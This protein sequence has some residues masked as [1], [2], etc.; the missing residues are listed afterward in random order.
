MALNWSLF[1]RL[2]VVGEAGTGVV[3]G[4]DKGER[5]GAGDAAREDVLAELL[6]VAGVLGGA[7]RSLDRVLEREVQGLR[8]EVPRDRK[9]VVWLL[10]FMRVSGIFPWISIWRN[11]I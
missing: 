10:Y 2:G 5:H 11:L 9:C 6:G 1:A 3:E 8:G 4:V 7:E